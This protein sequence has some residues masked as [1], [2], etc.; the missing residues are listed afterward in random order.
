[1][2]FKAIIISLIVG[3]LTVAPMWSAEAKPTPPQHGN[4]GPRN[5]ARSLCVTTTWR[6][7]HTHKPKTKVGQFCLATP[8]MWI[9]KK[10]YVV[11]LVLSPEYRLVE[12][13]K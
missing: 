4:G 5:P 13:V 6:A 12:R 7:E 8:D 9:S 2:K 3:M 1:M 10:Q 11:F